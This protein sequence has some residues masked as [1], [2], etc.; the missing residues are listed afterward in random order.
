MKEEAKVL[1]YP[2]DPNVKIKTASCVLVEQQGLFLAVSRKNNHKDFGLPGGK[3]DIGESFIQ[4]AI[5]ETLEE[6]GLLVNINPW[7]PFISK[8]GDS[9]VIT[10][11]GSVIEQKSEVD[12]KETGVVKYTTKED[13]CKG[14]FSAYNL[15]MF[16]HFGY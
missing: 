6:T 7:N 16:K 9:F 10:F 3:L 15:A 5:R 1:M 8:D 13:I 4:A 12:K 2:T 11:E 14:S